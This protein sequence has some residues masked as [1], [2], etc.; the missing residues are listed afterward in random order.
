M[1]NIGFSSAGPIVPLIIFVLFAVIMVALIFVS[2]SKQNKKNYQSRY[3]GGQ[4]RTQ[5]NNGLRTKQA[6]RKNA[7]Q[8]SRP[9]STSIAPHNDGHAHVGDDAE[10]YDKIV[11]SLGEVDDE[12]CD[13]LDGVRLIAHD[14]AYDD[15]EKGVDYTEVAK[16]IVIGEIVNNPRFKGKNK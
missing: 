15:E 7:E 8:N 11:G 16:A 14:I 9:C 2:K 3:S 1:Y 13:E 10:Y 6:Q 4:D 5:S 12:G